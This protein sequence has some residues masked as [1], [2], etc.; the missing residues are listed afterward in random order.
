MLFMMG[1]SG[2]G[3]F[4]DFGA[5]LVARFVIGCPCRGGIIEGSTG[6]RLA[7]IFL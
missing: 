4:A 2:G 7:R 5:G 6:S 1:V 3:R